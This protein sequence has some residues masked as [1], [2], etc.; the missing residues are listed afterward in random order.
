MN[1]TLTDDGRHGWTIRVDGRLAGA[2]F[3]ARVRDRGGA[4]FGRRTG[5]PARRFDSEHPAVA[6]VVG[7]CPG[8]DDQCPTCGPTVHH[9]IS[10]AKD[11]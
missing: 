5:S 8:L 7:G 9:P 6:Y 4:W 2:A 10:P 11:L 3:P 1:H